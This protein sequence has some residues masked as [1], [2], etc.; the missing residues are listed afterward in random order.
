MLQTMLV[1]LDSS[2]AAEAGLDW[3]SDAAERSGA[4]LRLLAV[5]GNGDRVLAEAYLRAQEQRLAM[6]GIP[7]TSE[8]ASGS[9]PDVILQ[10]A[11]EADLTVMTYGTRKW[12][13]GGALDVVMR[14]MTRPLVI[15]RGGCAPP[16]AAETVILVPLETAAYSRAVLGPVR[17]M[18]EALG[19]R[20]MLCHVVSPVGPYLSTDKMPAETAALMAQEIL[21]AMAELSGPAAGL[22]RVGLAV[23]MDARVGRPE[24]EIPRFARE[25]G[26]TLIA[27]AT[28]GHDRLSRVL[29]S[30][31]YS[32]V[33]S[34][35]IPCLLVRPEDGVSAAATA[36]NRA[37]A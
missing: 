36:D 33:Q 22:R 11:A 1:P 13:I 16:P 31:A 20:V 30:V 23:E 7:A 3:A 18:A 32:V 15:V 17:V 26:A 2:S 6:R 28:R 9:V 27:M 8:V 4:A 25:C 29:G 10:R 12:L 34:V 14:D 24:E 19:A 21:G 37:N 35:R 5:A